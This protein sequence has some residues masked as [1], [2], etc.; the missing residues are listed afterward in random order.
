VTDTL[1]NLSK[2]IIPL[3][4][5][6]YTFLLKSWEDQELTEHIQA[7]YKVFDLETNTMLPL[8]FQ[9]LFPMVELYP[10]KEYSIHVV[11]NGYEPVIARLRP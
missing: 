4:R 8:A 7:S 9:G 5:K 11:A 10:F 3:E 6:S 2:L 1:L